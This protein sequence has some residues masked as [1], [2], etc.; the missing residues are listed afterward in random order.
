MKT[1]PDFFF[2]CIAAVALV[3]PLTACAT[4]FGVD[5]EGQV[6]EEG[7]NK[8]IP[9]AIVIVRWAGV[10][11]MI[12]HASSVCVHVESAT[13]DKEGRYRTAAWR[14]PSTVGP[15]PLV[16]MN[17]GPGAYAYKPGYEYLD[18]RGETVYLKPFTGG[19]GERLAY[20]MRVLDGTR[21]G[22]KDESEKN[23]HLFYRALY[24]EGKKIAVTEREKDM[25]DTLRYWS[26]FVLFDPSK[27]SARDEKGRV[28]NIEPREQK[29]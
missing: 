1:L 25:V 29:K 14:A 9:E 27:P 12:G 10:I 4:L 22:A 15:A 6:L 16:Q 17:I 8:P 11:P 23:L 21:C 5:T 13:T 7:T 20:L 2:R 18:T 24:E 28:I 3:L 26:T 19:R